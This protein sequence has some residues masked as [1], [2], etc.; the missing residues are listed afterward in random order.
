MASH[1]SFIPTNK[2][3]NCRVF[4]V[5]TASEKLMSFEEYENIFGPNV[6]FN[7][8]IT[9]MRPLEFCNILPL[10]QYNSEKNK[11]TLNSKY[12]AFIREKAM[13]K[14]AKLEGKP[15]FNYGPARINTVYEDCVSECKREYPIS[16]FTPLKI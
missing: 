10:E 3:E 14:Y 5:K 8:N 11:I 7:N 6:A 12:N 2:N 9:S 13:S 1:I 15:D 16:D 4:N